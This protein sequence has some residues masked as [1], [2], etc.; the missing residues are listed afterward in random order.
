MG[1]DALNVY[2]Q[3]SKLNVYKATFPW[4]GDMLP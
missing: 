3:D 4:F 2:T 1:L